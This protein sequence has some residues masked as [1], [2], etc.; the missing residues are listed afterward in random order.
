LNSIL[1][2]VENVEIQ[3]GMNCVEVKPAA[4][5]KGIAVEILLKKVK[6]T[7]GPTDFV[8]CIGNN[9]IDEE[10]YSRILNPNNKEFFADNAHIF[11]T[12]I[13]RK[14]T[15]AQYYLN[16]IKDAYTVLESLC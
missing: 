15:N 9:S 14:P 4:I 1:E 3:V 7:K 12:T 13:G 16:T 2:H 10:M 5:N 6:T 11:T 8:L